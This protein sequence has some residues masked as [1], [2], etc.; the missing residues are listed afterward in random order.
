MKTYAEAVKYTARNTDI[1]YNRWVAYFL[2]AEIYD[3]TVAVAAHDVNVEVEIYA[4]EVL[5]ERK[6]ARE[7]AKA[8]QNEL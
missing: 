3:V 6:K 5:L 7:K 2:L 8:E 4:R 1:R